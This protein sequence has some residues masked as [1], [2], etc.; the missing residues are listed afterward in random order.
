MFGGFKASEIRQI[1]SIS[2]KLKLNTSKLPALMKARKEGKPEE[3]AM[4]EL[5]DLPEGVDAKTY[6]RQT[7]NESEYEV[8]R[9]VIE[10]YTQGAG[11]DP[12][13]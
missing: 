8:L 9:G 3:E 4:A 6:L 11:T 1:S 12:L 2:K 5:L 7:L 10:K 13:K